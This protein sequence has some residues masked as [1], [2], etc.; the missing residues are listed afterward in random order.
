MGTITTSGVGSGLDIESIV[1]KLV[2]AE[3]TPKRTQLQSQ[4]ASVQARLSAYGQ[5]RSALAQLQ[6]AVGTLKEAA[7]F[8][9]RSTTVGDADV[10]AASA[11]S[12]A[13]PGAYAVEVVRL[14]KGAKLAS[15]AYAA[16]AAAVGTGTLTLTSGGRTFAVAID[17]ANN[18]LSGI[19][20]AINAAK[21]NPGIAATLVTANDGVRLVLTSST[22]GSA[23][24][25]TVT[26]A[27]GDGGLAGLAYDPANGVTGL[28]SLQAAQDSRVV[29]DGFTYDSSSNTVTGAL[30]GVTLTLKKE[31]ATGV[32]VPLT[33]SVDN[34]KAQGAI[35]AF[36]AAYNQV[37][38]GL[39]AM[40]AYDASRR[41][42][43]P[44]VGDALLR[45]VTSSV[46]TQLGSVSP[47]LAGNA[48]T[49][50]ADVGITTNLDGTLK[51]DGAKLAAALNDSAALQ[52]LFTDDAGVARRLDA[53]LADYTRAG[54][55]I[56]SRTT[57]L[58]STLKDLDGQATAL[59]A[60]MTAYERRIRAQF[61]A[62]DTL[63]AQLRQTGQ[64][65]TAQLSTINPNYL[66]GR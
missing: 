13:A 57:G 54:G 2:Q 37:L 18:T 64:N 10:L 4:Q 62:M 11:G 36:A 20:D 22:T 60:R 19:R 59:D 6:T 27:G 41:Q 15:G 42:G 53:L 65:L 21:D 40:G 51:T 46:R 17:G 14:A 5:M 8:R 7:I 16:A 61:T 38:Q 55:L 9:S 26:Q 25:I 48:Y 43:G 47:G 1:S 39:R 34:A 12:A 58:Q 56:D 50:L 33:V 45:A 3:G 52:R 49:S 66:G 23:S 29:V 31:S 24:A 44:L 30:D 32:T 35:S 63:V 28:T